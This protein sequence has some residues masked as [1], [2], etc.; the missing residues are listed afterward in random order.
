MVGIQSAEAK[1]FDSHQGKILNPPYEKKYE[2]RKQVNKFDKKSYDDKFINKKH[3]ENKKMI[4]NNPYKFNNN[5]IHQK[6]YHHKKFNKH[7]KHNN[8]QCHQKRNTY[9]R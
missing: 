9:Y 6:K 5:G 1:S 7:F 4:S 3:Y 2:H 8:F